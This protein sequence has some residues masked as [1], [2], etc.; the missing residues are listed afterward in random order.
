MLPR[1]LAGARLG[2]GRRT[3]ISASDPVRRDWPRAGP[4]DLRAPGRHAPARRLAGRPPPRRPAPRPSAG[5]SAL[6]GPCFRIARMEP[7][8]LDDSRG[9]GREVVPGQQRRRGVEMLAEFGSRFAR[10]SAT[11]RCPS[12]IAVRSASAGDDGSRARACCS[13]LERAGEVASAERPAGG[14]QQRDA[15][16]LRRHRRQPG[17]RSG[18]SR[19]RGAERSRGRVEPRSRPASPLHCGRTSKIR[20]SGARR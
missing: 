17:C 20:P 2:S 15:L 3:Y 9:C 6:Y 18:S 8:R 19:P 4:A 7:Q 13:T 16:L 12:A 5:R 11:A 1:A 14:A 10:V